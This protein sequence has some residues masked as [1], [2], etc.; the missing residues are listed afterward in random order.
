MTPLDI[1]LYSL[2]GATAAFA[3]IELGL[4]V[5]VTSF[6]TGTQRVPVYNYYSGYSYQNVTVKAP[7][8]LIFMLFNASW[9]ILVSAGA[10]I[11]PWFFGRKGAVTAK[12][13]LVLG[14]V[15]SILYFVTMAFWLATF[16]DIVTLL[17]GYPSDSDYL[18]AII[19]FAVLLW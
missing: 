18:N 14:I 17:G 1:S 11:T 7:P 19:A 10:L 5:A 16:A 12:L 3:V 9:T 8:I 6:E 4:A 2:L 15:M 13:N